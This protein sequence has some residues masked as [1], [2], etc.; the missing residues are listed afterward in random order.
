MNLSYDA[1]SCHH[2]RRHPRTGESETPTVVEM[3]CAYRMESKNCVGHTKPTSCTMYTEHMRRYFSS[4][5]HWLVNQYPAGSI[6]G[7]EKDAL[8][9][10]RQMHTQERG[11]EKMDV[12]AGALDRRSRCLTIS[13]QIILAP[14]WAASHCSGLLCT[15]S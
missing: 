12:I 7:H 4:V 2:S 15:I 9:L 11:G 3:Y 8:I 10:D 5:S 6:L 13:M 14:M 1:S